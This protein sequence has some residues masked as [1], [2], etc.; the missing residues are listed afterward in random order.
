MN[1]LELEMSK[2]RLELGK[3]ICEEMVRLD[4]NSLRLDW[5][6]VGLCTPVAILL[7]VVGVVYLKDEKWIL[8]IIE[9]LLALL[10]VGLCIN[11]VSRSNIIRQSLKRHKADLEEINSNI[12]SLKE[13]EL[14]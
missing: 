12:E 5:M 4:K 8:A 2:S 13:V 6:I 7:V 14:E 1:K 11:A 3:E 10:N 9:F